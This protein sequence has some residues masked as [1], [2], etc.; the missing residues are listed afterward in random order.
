MVFLQVVSAV[1]WAGGNKETN[2]TSTAFFTGSGGSEMRLGI[3]VPQS[4]GL[5]ENQNYL[6]SLIQGVLVS[7][8]SKYSA[9]SVLDRVALDKVIGET[10]DPTYE[11]YL[12]IVRLG[13]V[14][15]VVIINKTWSF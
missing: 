1:C 14:A 4:Q 6:P 8:I 2:T 10:L 12:E 5:N 7:N 11:D 3:L 9:I 13:H 15:Q